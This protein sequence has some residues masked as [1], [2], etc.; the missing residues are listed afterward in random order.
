MKK[1]LDD[2]QLF[3]A[4]VE[5][6][7][8]K[9]A[10][11]HLGVPHS[12]VSRR[13]EALESNLKLHLLHRTTREVTVTHRGEQLYQECSP[14]LESIDKAIDI[15]IHDEITLK[16][17]LAISMPV[18]AGLDFLGNWLI[19]FAKQYDDLNLQLSLSNT[20]LNLVQENIDLAFRVGPLADSSAIA[21][22]LWDIPYSLYASQEFIAQYN[23]GNKPISLEQLAKLPSVITLPS[24]SWILINQQGE[25]H[26]FQPEPKL[27]V[28]DLALA[29]HA[30]ESGQV[31]GLLPDEMIT[32]KA[33]LPVTIAGYTARSRAMFAYYMGRRHT[34]S[35]IQH[36]IDYV[37]QKRGDFHAQ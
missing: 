11:E 28:D 26:S 34:I 1:V 33:L 4:V 24:R 3:C 20:N 35:Q 37:K 14:L 10:S 6:G 5:K 21:I 19:D 13:I 2:L 32:H 27:V 31:I 16:G 23:I 15:A 25:E 22:K 8:L 7:S 9:A 18:R 12:T 30:V 17:S 29:L 36:V